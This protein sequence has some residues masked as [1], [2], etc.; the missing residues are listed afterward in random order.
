MDPLRQFEQQ[1]RDAV[2]AAF[3]QMGADV[4][5]EI[6]VPSTGVADFAVPC[7]PLAKV[8]RKAPPVIAEEAASKLPALDLVSRAWAEKGYLNFKL[9]DRKVNVATLGAIMRMKDDYGRG[10]AS[11]VKVL[12]EHTSV[13]P[14]GPIHVG[15]ARNPIIGDTLARC[16]RA[17]GYDVTTEYYVNDVGKQV[18]LLTWGLE[19][20][21]AGD[22]PAIE[23]EK[24][25]HRLVVYYQKANKMMED[26]PE[27]AK[28]VGQMLRRFEDG[29]EE[30][31]AKVRKTAKLMLDGI[32]ESLESIN[33]V[34]DQFTWES[35]FIKDGTAH[36]V[37]ERLKRSEH[38]GQDQGAC[39]LELKPFGIHGKETRFFF[40]RADG[41]TLYTTRDMAYHLDKFKRA[42]RTINILGEDQKLG[43]AQLAIALKL[44][45]QERAPE[46]V[47]Y[48]F[49]SL[50]EGRMSTRKGT[51]VYLDD[52]IEEAVER[53]LEEVRKRRTDLSEERMAEIAKAIGRG[54]V[55]YNI[56]RVQPEKPLVF[57]WEDAL[58]FEGNSAPFVQYAHAR[59]CSIQRKAGTSDAPFDPAALTNEY[60]LKLIRT[61][62]RY[63]S[64]IREAGEKQRIQALPAYGHEVASAFNQF[65]TYVPVLKG[66]E[67][68]EARLALVDATRIVLANVLTTLGL[69]A[70]EEM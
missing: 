29:D 40:T 35:Q 51:V 37:V 10:N 39:Y 27:V 65:Y 9:D 19:N 20:I 64:V 56:A 53:A 21:P 32:I 50:P 1:I 58:N 3:G 47:F 46:C 2:K 22:V 60:E 5:F 25:D 7:F 68:R 44:L 54:A 16:M 4:P 42:D 41:T 52:L 38:C 12:L 61:L 11:G 63:P 30:V 31:M 33:V 55:R 49:V 18:V 62:A 8:M 69:S 24:A 14:T 48:S 36:N 67:N 43:Q 66:E 45:G 15:R 17:Y 28:Q 13:N 6:E 26:D 23:S 57:K 59:A 70:P 34:I